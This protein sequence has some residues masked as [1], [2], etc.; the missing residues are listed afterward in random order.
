MVITTHSGENEEFN[1]EL[2]NV[3][4]EL[5]KETEGVSKGYVASI[6]LGRHQYLKEL[7]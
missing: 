3:C 2:R 1:Q 4:I 7:Y 5:A 6:L